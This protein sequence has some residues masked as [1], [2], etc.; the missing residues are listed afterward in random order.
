MK[1]KRTL[2]HPGKGRKPLQDCWKRVHQEMEDRKIQGGTA[3]YK[4]WFVLSKGCRGLGTSTCDRD[5]LPVV[6]R[7]Q[8]LALTHW[9]SIIA[10]EP[11][12]HIS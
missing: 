9:Q 4:P 8:K 12:D 7:L 3:A 5:T 10:G 2:L 11:V 6:T 1:K